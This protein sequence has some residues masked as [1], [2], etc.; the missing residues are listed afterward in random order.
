MQENFA[1]F[2]YSFDIRIV[3]T[4]SKSVCIEFFVACYFGKSLLTSYSLNSISHSFLLNFALKHC[5][6][7]ILDTNMKSLGHYCNILYWGEN[8]CN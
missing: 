3:I 6:L 4:A 2:F 8:P 1:D 7:N 5:F